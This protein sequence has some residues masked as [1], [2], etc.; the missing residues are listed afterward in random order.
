MATSNA[1]ILV[2][3]AIFAFALP[4]SAAC[5]ALRAYTAEEGSV[6]WDFLPHESPVCPQN[7]GL[8]STK[9]ESLL[10]L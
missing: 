6:I 4:A 10:S 9:S 3:S 5:D 1:T 7:D 2:T 8:W